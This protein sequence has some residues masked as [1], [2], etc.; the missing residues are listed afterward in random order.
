VVLLLFSQLKKLLGVDDEN[1]NGFP[2]HIFTHAIHAHKLM[3]TIT[4][5]KK[6]GYAYLKIERKVIQS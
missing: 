3:Q 6:S 1:V 5:K 4:N 2:P